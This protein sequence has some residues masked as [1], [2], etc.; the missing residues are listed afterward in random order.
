MISKFRRVKE[1][2]RLFEGEA[3]RMRMTVRVDDGEGMRVMVRVG[4]GEGMRVRVT[5]G[6]GIRVRGRG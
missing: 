2:I 4:E 3:G 1:E 6:E 5:V